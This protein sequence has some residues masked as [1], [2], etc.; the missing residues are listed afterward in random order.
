MNAAVATVNVNVIKDGIAGDLKRDEPGP[1]YVHIPAWVDQGYFAEMAAESRTAKGWIKTPGAANEALD[2]HA[3][4]R[5]ALI[6][7]KAESIDWDHPPT[8]AAPIAARAAVN[9]TD[10]KAAP[11][12]RMRSRGI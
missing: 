8:W 7:M 9:P 4:N 6:A 5:A 1:G 3:Y 2:L 12:R 11:G 10:I